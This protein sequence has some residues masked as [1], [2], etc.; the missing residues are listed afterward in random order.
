MKLSTATLSLVAAVASGVLGNPV[1]DPVAAPAP[2]AGGPVACVVGSGP[3]LGAFCT[4]SQS[5]EV[6][7]SNDCRSTVSFHSLVWP[8]SLG[9]ITTPDIL[10]LDLESLLI[11]KLRVVPLRQSFAP[12]HIPVFLCPWNHVLYVEL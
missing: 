9:W 5:N 10:K 6:W 8:V 4:D 7:C 11:Y 1:P 2:A 12:I 3:A